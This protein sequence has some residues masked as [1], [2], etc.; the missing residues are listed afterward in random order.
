MLS[1]NEVVNIKNAIEKLYNGTCNIFES[2]K[3]VKEN[4]STGFEEVKIL[5]DQPCRL[6]FKTI[7]NSKQTNLEAETKQII[8][9]FISSEIAVKSG[10]KIEVTQNGKTEIYKNS[11]K[12]AI[13]STHQEIILEIFQG[14]A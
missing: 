2:Q 5:E 7:T 1:E 8:K 10:S 6:S 11:G 3:V 13:Y 12:P 14:W 4:K 9:L